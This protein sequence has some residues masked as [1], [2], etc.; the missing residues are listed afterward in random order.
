MSFL[1]DRINA[2][3]WTGRALR[4]RNFRLFFMGQG[5]SLIGTWMQRMALQWF[6]YNWTHNP[7]LL[8]ALD[9]SSQIPAFLIAPWAGLLADR[10]SRHRLIVITQAAAMLQAAIL[11]TLVLTGTVQLWHLFALALLLGCINGFDI[12][13]R[14]SFLVETVEKRADLGNA[15]ALNASVFNAARLVGPSVAGFILAITSAGIC[16]LLNAVSYLAVIWALL[17]MRVRRAV[18]RRAT[19]PGL[20]GLY[21][22]LRYVWSFRTMGYL[23]VN[24]SIVAIAGGPYM[25]LMPV[26]AKRVLGGGPQTLGLLI[27]AVGIGALTG[28][29][30]LA[31]R[32]GPRGLG[33]VMA[34]AMGLYSLGLIAFSHSRFIPLSMA[35]LVPVGLGMM[36]LMAGTN[37]LLQTLVEEDK[38]GRVMALYTMA[39]MGSMPIGSLWGGAA[40]THIGAP[41]TVFIGGLFCVVATLVFLSRLRAMR[42]EAGPIL[43]AQGYFLPGQEPSDRS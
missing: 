17:A 11:A 13:L 43:E 27:A 5:I 1:A 16:F 32:Q 30:F 28:A 18:G 2:L 14:Q 7:W 39:F 40:A 10:F 34:V 4:H 21:E 20:H 25:T 29:F 31:S 6:V 12:P 33:R 8:G 35:I 24:L 3:R 26:F 23:L 22:G 41:R 38:R 42:R 15:I 36:V 19:A 37:T 9:F